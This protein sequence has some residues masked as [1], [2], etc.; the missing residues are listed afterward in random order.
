[1]ISQVNE[2]ARPRVLI[3]DDD[4]QVGRAIARVLELWTVVSLARGAA[5]ALALI[6]AG[7]LFDLILCDVMMSGA[8]GTS[9]YDQ[10]VAASPRLLGR[11]V[12]MTAGPARDE[13]DRIALRGL[14]CLSKPLSLETLHALVKELAPAL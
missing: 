6:E 8:G 10:A 9:F 11:V 3:V 7:E 5:E 4:S 13:A 2:P 1:M 12:L 14:R